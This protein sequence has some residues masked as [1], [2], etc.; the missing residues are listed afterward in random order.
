MTPSSEITQAK[1]LRTI[2]T[3]GLVLCLLAIVAGYIYYGMQVAKAPAV[4]TA[5]NTAVTTEMSP[6]AAEILE[7]LEAAPTASPESSK[8]T[9]E[10]LESATETAT[11]EEQKAILDALGYPAGQ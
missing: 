1:V 10:A 9:V 11:P 7:A 8:A 5:T 2:I 4:D 3:I 6:S